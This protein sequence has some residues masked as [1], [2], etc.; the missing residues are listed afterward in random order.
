MTRTPIPQHDWAAAA[1]RIRRAQLAAR[2][3]C[4]GR[5]LAF[6]GALTRSFDLG[7]SR[8]YEEG[9]NLGSGDV[10]EMYS[11][12]DHQRRIDQEWSPN[13]KGKAAP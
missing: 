10:P 1:E 6:A 12:M 13:T 8:G 2:L 9:D 11:H 7:W 5:N 3:H 4:L